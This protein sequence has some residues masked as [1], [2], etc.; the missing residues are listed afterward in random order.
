V[1]EKVNVWELMIS[2][3]VYIRQTALNGRVHVK[4]CL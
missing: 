2:L 4:V 3:E 1:R